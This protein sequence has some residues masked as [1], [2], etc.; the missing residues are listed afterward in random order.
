MKKTSVFSLI[1]LL[2]FL[3]TFASRG[4]N[5]EVSNV[6][7]SAKGQSQG[8]FDYYKA[9]DANYNIGAGI[10]DITGPA[11]ES[12]MSGYAMAE[13]KAE[14]LQGRLWARTFII[15]DNSGKRIVYCVNEGAWISQGARTEIL[16]KLASKN[17]K[18]EEG[19]LFPLL[20]KKGQPLYTEDNVLISASHSHAALAGNSHHT[21]TN[22]TG[23]GYNDEVFQAT[24]DG[25]V[26]SI[27]RAH[28]NIKPAIIEYSEGLINKD[29]NVTYNRSIEPFL[30][31]PEIIAKDYPSAEEVETWTEEEVKELKLS[32]DVVDKTMYMLK[33][34][35][36]VNGSPIGLL[37]W[38]AVHPTSLSNSNLY[39]SADNLGYA[40]LAV[41]NIM[42]TDYSARDT[43]IAAFAQGSVGDSCNVAATDD[44]EIA[45][46][47]PEAGTPIKKAFKEFP[48]D[49]R[50]DFEYLDYVGRR[51][52]QRAIEIF[53]E[54]GSKIEG[55]I[56]FAHS[57]LDMSKVFVDSEFAY[58]A[59]TYE[60]RTWPGATGYSMA[61]GAENGPS[62]VSGFY[63]GF[64]YGHPD[65]K[66]IGWVEAARKFLTPS[67]SDKERKLGLTNLISRT[68]ELQAVQAPK[69]VLF[70]VG[71]TN[72]E[73][74]PQTLPLQGFTIGDFAVFAYAH[75]ITTISAARLK[76]QI[77]DSFSKN[78][79]DI[80][81]CVVASASNA[82][83]H[84]MATP[85]EYELQHYEGG[86]TQFGINQLGA[87][88]QETTRLID[89][90]ANNLTGVQPGDPM[91]VVASPPDLSHNLWTFF[92]DPVRSLSPAGKKF[93]EEA[94]KPNKRFALKSE[95]KAGDLLEVEFVSA[96]LKID[97]RT[98]DSYFDIQRQN[99]ET[100][101][102]YIVRTD[103][104][105]DTKL[106]W[107]KKTSAQSNVIVKW[108][109][110]VE[111]NP[112]NY[113]IVHKGSYRENSKKIVPFTYITADF[114]ITAKDNFKK[115]GI[116]KEAG[117]S[118]SLALEEGTEFKN[119]VIRFEPDSEGSV[120]GGYLS[121]GDTKIYLGAFSKNG[122]AKVIRLKPSIVDE[123]EFEILSQ[124][125]DNYKAKL[126]EFYVY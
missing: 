21:M 100:G 73:W 5:H 59:D 93:G 1:F 46:V 112:G 57:Y 15:E 30:K 68:D 64:I 38:F 84:Y 20:D 80:N 44:M 110:P 34:I 109:I 55:K 99:P 4:I 78:N 123:I 2:A 75:E 94:A 17:L 96:H 10:Y 60:P 18:D 58:K 85:E 51:I 121:Y 61:A 86:C 16:R 71:E 6:D 81:K 104:D 91:W 50:R 14:G 124:S 63:E 97:L 65:H 56:N 98:M 41:E 103:K 83:S 119:I 77:L 8:L 67:R 62:F 66:L 108:E 27:I 101:K 49:K 120:T 12:H 115:Q 122:E 48:E 102:W 82:Y 87:Y 35:D 54:K 90:M 9:T 22:F 116:I 113:R 70:A 19:N 40:S 7:D 43:F 118:F 37:S 111:V 76:K 32:E 74:S 36:P 95:Y 125:S 92:K 25:I 24:V 28:K 79:I 114:E 23:G 52:S 42:G 33:F 29:F 26:Q 39:V 47:S 126:A 105:I 89:K 11:A 45:L 53:S 117:S 88:L 3:N 107:N 13:Q 69:A 31:N 106:K 72:P